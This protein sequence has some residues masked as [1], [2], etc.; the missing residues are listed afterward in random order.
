MLPLIIKKRSGSARLLFLLY[1]KAHENFRPRLVNL[2][3]TT[4]AA[5]ADL[6]PPPHARHPTPPHSQITARPYR[7]TSL[8]RN[9]SDKNETV[10]EGKTYRGTLLTR[11]RTP[12][13]LTVELC[14][15]GS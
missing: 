9:G 3:L 15:L 6:H 7:G 8:I 5:L 2:S 14:L 4:L 12:L 10:F 13:G 1:K 11:E